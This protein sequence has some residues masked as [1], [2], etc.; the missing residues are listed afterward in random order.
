MNPS[1]KFIKTYSVTEREY[2]RACEET[3]LRYREE[4]KPSSDLSTLL[5][6]ENTNS[7]LS[8]QA[9]KPLNVFQTHSGSLS[10]YRHNNYVEDKTIPVAKSVA[11]AVV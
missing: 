1:S 6:R 9:L 10:Y 3:I 11:K 8:K 5:T 2:S 7:F 4:Y